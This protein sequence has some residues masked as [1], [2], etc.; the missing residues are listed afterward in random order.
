MSG[1]ASPANAVR[2]FSCAAVHGSCWTLTRMPGLVCSNSGSSL[3]TTSPSRPI[4]QNRRTVSSDADGPQPAASAKA[5]TIEKSLMNALGACLIT[6]LGEP[7]ARE[8]G[9]LQAAPEIGILA[10]DAPDQRAPV[11]FDHG[12][13]RSL[14]DP[15]V[16]V[17]VGLLRVDGAPAVL[18]VID[19]APLHVRVAD[20]A[21]I[22]PYVRVLM[23]E[24]RREAQELLAEELAP[25][26]V[27]R[28]GPFGP[29]IRLDG[30]GR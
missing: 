27:V 4:A 18:E 1:V 17:G 11:V 6:W 28:A 16:G 20:A 25:V 24:Q 9:P 10:H 12:E 15:E 7:A 22:R 8:A 13:D 3:A 26:L 14:V 29:R 5:T 21:E 2:S 19:A 30:E 23:S